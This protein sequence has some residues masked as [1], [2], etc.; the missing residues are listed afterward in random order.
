MA[1]IRLTPDR[2]VAGTTQPQFPPPPNTSTGPRIT[3]TPDRILA[4]QAAGTGLPPQPQYAPPPGY[5][6]MPEWDSRW[7]RY[8]WT[9]AEDRSA[10][11][12]GGG[13][14]Y[15]GNP[16]TVTG[17]VYVVDL[18]GGQKAIVQDTNYG[19]QVIDT[20]ATQQPVTLGAPPPGFVGVRDS[21]GNITQWV[22]DPSFVSPFDQQ[23][24]FRDY[25]LDVADLVERRKQ[26]AINKGYLDLEQKKYEE[27]IRQFNAQEER[28]LYEFN[29]R[30]EEDVANRLQRKE[31]LEMELRSLE[32]RADLD[33]QVRRE[34]IRAEIQNVQARIQADLQIA[35]LQ[36]RDKLAI[37]RQEAAVA[38]RGQDVE[39][40]GQDINAAVAVRGQ[41]IGREANIMQSRAELAR[42]ASTL[43]R[44]NEAQ[45]LY[46]GA[47]LT[48]KMLYMEEWKKSLPPMPQIEA[49]KP[50]PPVRPVAIT[51]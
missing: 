1:R 39:M 18:G 46:G 36:S 43:D 15:S 4:G 50:P 20:F 35:Q 13:G 24:F 10:G 26:T 3:Q 23:K 12:R 30:L 33:A 9:L 34:Q 27:G 51:V 17:S 41:D 6:W 21:Q 5:V 7:Q 19:P 32:R 16:P 47:G 44:I 38:M 42:Y 49:Y 2:I 40:R 11:G 45:M 48:P 22:N 29:K 28:L 25:E 8:Y 37:A 14:G 31:E